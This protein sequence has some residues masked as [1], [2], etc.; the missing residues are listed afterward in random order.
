MISTDM[1]KRLAKGEYGADRLKPLKGADAGAQPKPDG[2]R[3]IPRE[4]VFQNEII[5][6]AVCTKCKRMLH[7]E[8]FYKVNKPIDI[9]SWCREC[10]RVASRYNYTK[11]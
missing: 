10:T 11:R 8:C 9:S 4:F 3:K 5:S 7:R 2:P 1:W 6:Q